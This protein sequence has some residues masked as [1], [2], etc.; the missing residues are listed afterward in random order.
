MVL[1]IWLGS[2]NLSQTVGYIVIASFGFN[3]V[4]QVV[5]E[6]YKAK[7][8]NKRKFP[9]SSGECWRKSRKF[10]LQVVQRSSKQ[11]CYVTSIPRYPFSARYL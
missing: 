1:G 5:L 8:L 9:V 7:E 10:L 2:L 3:A 6:L 4:L 11:K